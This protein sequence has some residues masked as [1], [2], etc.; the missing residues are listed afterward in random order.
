MTMAFAMQNCAGSNLRAFK[1]DSWGALT[2]GSAENRLRMFLQVRL[3]KPFKL[4]YLSENYRVG[5][6][7]K[8][9]DPMGPEVRV[10][11][12][13][14][15]A[16]VQYTA[17]LAYP[18]GKRTTMIEYAIIWEPGDTN[19]FAHFITYGYHVQGGT[20]STPGKMSW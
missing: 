13:R 12:I 19:S 2:S 18:M 17:G 11:I 5:A 9:A 6:L 7:I 14:E 15:R 20:P 8:P 1:W 3:D 4:D 16:V 10:G